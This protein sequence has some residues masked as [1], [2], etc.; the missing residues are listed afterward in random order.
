MTTML[1]RRLAPLGAI[2]LSFALFAALGRADVLFTFGEMARL[3]TLEPA[4]RRL[5]DEDLALYQ[6]FELYAYTVF[7]ALQIA[8]D[9]AV[10]VGQGT[11]PLS[12]EGRELG[13][14]RVLGGV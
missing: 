12:R 14:R 9:A 6:N 13:G 3:Q 11:N 4:E 5:S 10:G 2:A 1:I 8:N 7:E